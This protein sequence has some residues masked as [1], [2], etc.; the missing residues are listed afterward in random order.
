MG[1]VQLQN[2]RLMQINM[3]V[4]DLNCIVEK[5]YDKMN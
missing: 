4:L 1:Q 5:L 3:E 2:I